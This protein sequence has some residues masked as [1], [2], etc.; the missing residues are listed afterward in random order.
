M[1]MEYFMAV[2]K[3]STLPNSRADP[4]V[5]P[6]IEWAPIEALRPNPKKAR[7]HSK[8]QIRRIAASIRQLGFLNPLIVD[9]A[10]VV[11]AGHGRLEAARLEGW[12]EVPLLRFGHLSEAQKRAYVIAD[13]KIAEQAGWDRKILALELGELIDLLPTE[14]LDVSLTGFEVA[15]IDLLMADLATPRLAPEDAVVQP[16]GDPV[17]LPG[18]LWLLAKHRLLCGDAQ[19]PRDFE[20]LMGGRPA[21][22]VFC[23]PPYNVR[24]RSIVGRGRIRHFEFAFASGEMEPAQFRRFLSETL[25]NGVRASV[26]G[27]VHYCVH[28]LASHQAIDRGRTRIVRRDAEPGRME[29]V[30]RW[31]G[32]FLPLTA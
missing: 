16:S 3:S 27:A 4:S 19:E 14:D 10:N 9:D 2:V 15:E 1:A 30:E 32:I 11:L 12:S 18:D 17:T 5:L 8:K 26:E 21:A 7:T 31:A 29:Q 28:G 22:A 13:N 6:Q 25:G 23:D 20:R 24:V